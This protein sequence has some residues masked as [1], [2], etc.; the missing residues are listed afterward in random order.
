MD[1]LFFDRIFMEQIHE[2]ERA[3]SAFQELEDKRAIN[4]R[5][6]EILQEPEEGHRLLTPEVFAALTANQKAEIEPDPTF[7]TKFFTVWNGVQY[8]IC[9]YTPETGEF[10]G[11]KALNEVEWGFFSLADFMKEKGPFGMKMERS[12][13]FQPTRASD[14]LE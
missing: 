1:A 4:Q 6:M 14:V 3:T 9:S 10:Y 12:L 5:L 7:L 2:D 8:F 11:I 13:S